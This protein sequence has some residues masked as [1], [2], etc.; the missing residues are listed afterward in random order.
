MKSAI[1]LA[2]VSAALTVLAACGDK[3]PESKAAKDIGNIPKQTVDKATTGVENA[4]TQG[5]DR[6]K[7]AEAKK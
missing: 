3:V 4:M 7:D 2:A 6:L 1:A 5:A